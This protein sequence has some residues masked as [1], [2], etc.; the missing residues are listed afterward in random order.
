[1]AIAAL[2]RT[3]AELVGRALGELI[4]E[5]LTDAELG[6]LREL[7]GEPAPQHEPDQAVDINYVQRLFPDLKRAALYSIAARSRA[8]ST[9]MCAG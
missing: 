3:L 5:R 2:R 9:S 8:A 6:Q 7:L 4:A 1:M